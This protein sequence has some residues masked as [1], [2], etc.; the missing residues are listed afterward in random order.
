MDRKKIIDLVI[1][2]FENST[3]KKLTA[4]TLVLCIVA[5]HACWLIYA[6]KNK[7]FSLL[8]FILPADMAGVFSILGITYYEK[9]NKTETVNQ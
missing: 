9:K 8:T 7:D 5:I 3:S 2:S 4:C 1:K 6:C